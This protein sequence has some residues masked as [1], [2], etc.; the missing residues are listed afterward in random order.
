MSTKTLLDPTAPDPPKNDNNVA[1]SSSHAAKPT[2]T[3]VWREATIRMRYTKTVIRTLITI[4]WPN[5]SAVPQNTVQHRMRRLVGDAGRTSGRKNTRAIH[6][7]TS[8]VCCLVCQQPHSPW[9]FARSK[10]SVVDDRPQNHN[11]RTDRDSHIV[12]M[13][14][15]KRE[16]FDSQSWVFLLHSSE[17]RWHTK[18][19][20]N[21][22]SDLW[23]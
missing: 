14:V 20:Q 13:F 2:N 12:Y 6:I 16:P 10:Q 18:R 23:W 5:I 21:K 11:I 4:Q 17:S 9:N 19:V 7:H 8:H 3:V 1:T 22:T 15:H